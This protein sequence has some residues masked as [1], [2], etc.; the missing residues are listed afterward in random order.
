LPHCEKRQHPQGG[1]V[2]RRASRVCISPEV[3]RGRL[4]DLLDI[5][6]V[7]GGLPCTVVAPTCTAHKAAVD[8][9][10]VTQLGSSLSHPHLR[11]AG[12]LQV[13]P[14]SCCGRR[15]AVASVRT[16]H[17][18]L[19]KRKQPFEP[20]GKG[21]G[22]VPVHPLRLHTH[23]TSP[24]QALLTTLLETCCTQRL[25]CSRTATVVCVMS[26]LHSGVLRTERGWLTAVNGATQ[27]SCGFLKF[28]KG[29]TEGGF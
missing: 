25:T 2:Q 24:A 12:T 22:G 10:R 3:C 6:G 4:E 14:P 28:R 21:C 13:I 18:G 8:L 1:D 23:R 29:L 20:G 9:N 11:A 19:E 5:G 17:Q 15:A 26:G 27:R 7:L 16:D